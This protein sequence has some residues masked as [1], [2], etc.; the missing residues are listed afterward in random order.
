ML[1]LLFGMLLS[2]LEL[3]FV[4]WD[5]LR[6]LTIVCVE[7]L[8]AHAVTFFTEPRWF[9]TQ[10]GQTFYRFS[11]S[12]DCVKGCS[13]LNIKVFAV[14]CLECF[15]SFYLFSP[16][17]GNLLSILAVEGLRCLRLLV[18][19]I[20]MNHSIIVWPQSIPVF[21]FWCNLDHFTDGIKGICWYQ[22]NH[23]NSALDVFFLRP[24]RFLQ[25]CP[26][27]SLRTTALS[28]INS[29]NNKLCLLCWDGFL[30]DKKHTCVHTWE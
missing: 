21:C 8:K 26:T 11:K 23:W 2:G 17:S 10:R 9:V 14:G 7:V 29:L 25:H 22:L 18:Y 13:W 15:L 27:L 1:L 3:A 16:H 12:S 4:D 20:M 19:L 24:G 28:H 6:L 5:K 30:G